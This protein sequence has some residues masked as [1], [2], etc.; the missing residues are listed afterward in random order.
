MSAP[1][2]DAGA[3][4]VVVVATG[5]PHKVTEIA[6]I[7]EGVAVTL[8]ALDADV[9]LPPEDEDTFEGNALVKARAAAR[10]TGHAAIADDSGIEVDALDGA[11]G[12]R[13]ARYAGQPTDD[14]AN[15]L[16][17][18]VELAARGATEPDARRARFVSAAALALPDGT[19]VVVRGTME[20]RVAD[21]PRGTGGFGYDPLFLADA[22]GG[23]RTTAELT[24]AE[25]DAISHRGA[26]FRALRPHLE[27][28]VV[29]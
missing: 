20:G 29:G 10:A 3:R 2:A 21:A 4:P 26:A 8:V 9:V 19:E 22:L 23:G 28:L 6:A 13:S 11:P 24:P 15:N 17:L 25:K 16:R 18:V 1:G 5:N 27:R 12:V 14:A 7:L